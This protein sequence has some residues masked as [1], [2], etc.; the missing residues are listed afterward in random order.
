[1]IKTGLITLSLL[2]GALTDAQAADLCQAANL[3]MSIDHRDGQYDG[4]SHR[5][6][7]LDI[8]NTGTTAC[9]LDAR[10]DL[11]FSGTLSD[12]TTATAKAKSSPGMHPGPVLPPVILAPQQTQHSLIRWVSGDMFDDGHNC[13]T[14]GRALLSVGD[15]TLSTAA[16]FYMCAPE[17]RK[18]YFELG[19]P[20]VQ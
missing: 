10:P 19:T 15:H 1:M 4:M 8:R 12:G 11:I 5:G 9:K 3:K 2:A 16:E 17:G 7:V 14:T 6:V 18:D 13:I 20:D